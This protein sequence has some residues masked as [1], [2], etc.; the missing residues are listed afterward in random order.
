M[1]VDLAALVG[2]ALTFAA[3][4]LPVVAAAGAKFAVRYLGVAGNAALV[5]EITDAASRGAGL[6]YHILA[7]ESAGV[8]DVA[9]H[10]VALARAANYVTQSAPAALAALGVT[11]DHV[12][13]MVRGELGKLLAAHPGVAMVPVAQKPALATAQQLVQPGSAAQAG[14]A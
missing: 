6:A 12:A 10:N 1:H 8:G 2:L 5:K 7:V 9:I 4:V 13:D 3:T 11:P 14:A